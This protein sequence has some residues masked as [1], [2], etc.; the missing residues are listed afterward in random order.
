MTDFMDRCFQDIDGRIPAEDG[1]PVALIKDMGMPDFD[2]ELTF[3][4]PAVADKDSI[5]K[6]SDSID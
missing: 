3:L 4:F 2:A 5:N 6:M 1:K